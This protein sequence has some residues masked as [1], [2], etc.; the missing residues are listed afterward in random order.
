MKNVLFNI[1]SV[2]TGSSKAVAGAGSRA[3]AGAG[4]ET[5]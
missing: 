4:A 3:G 1:K 5:F 2:K